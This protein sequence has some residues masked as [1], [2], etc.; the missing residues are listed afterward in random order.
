VLLAVNGGSSS[1]K[2]ALFSWDEHPQPLDR[3]VL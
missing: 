2:C 3:G 1:V